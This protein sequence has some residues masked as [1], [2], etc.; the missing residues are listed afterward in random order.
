MTFRASVAGLLV[1]VLLILGI[2]LTTLTGQWKTKNSKKPARYTKGEFLGEANPADIRGSYTFKDIETAFDIPVEV[3]A[4]A[5]GLENQQNPSVIQVKSFESFYGE[6][7]GKEIGTDSMRLFV[8]LY[9]NQPY[10]PKSMSVLPQMARDV[11]FEVGV[12]VDSG[13]FV[14]IEGS[15]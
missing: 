5:F 7:D 14:D 10:I 11:L 4:K 2:G 12:N 3:L 6:M 1:P 8:A 15:E 9:K 13:F